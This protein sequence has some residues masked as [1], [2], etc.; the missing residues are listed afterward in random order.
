MVFHEKGWGKGRS[1]KNLSAS[2]ER[3]GEKGRRG[4]EEA[5]GRRGGG[6]SVEKKKA[7]YRRGEMK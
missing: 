1:G 6:G 2:F 5:S 4:G 3:R 7:R